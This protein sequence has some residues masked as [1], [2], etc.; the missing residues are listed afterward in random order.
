MN[1][2]KPSYL[3]SYK[4]NPPYQPFYKIL[5]TSLVIL[6][7]IT[8]TSSAYYQKLRFT[9]D[10]EFT[11][12]QLTDLHYGEGPNRDHNSTILTERLLNMTNPDLVV[13]TGDSVSG[14]AWDGLNNTFYYDCWKMWTSPM[15]KLGIPYAY[16]LGNHDDQGDYNRKQICNL[17]ST[18]NF[19]LTQF[20]PSVTG[21]SNYFVPIYSSNQNDKTPVSL[22][23]MLDTNDENCGEMLDSW[24]CFEE[25]EIKWYEEE[26][27]RINKQF[28]YTPKGLAF[29]HI[30][31]P[32]YIESYNWRKSYGSRN[33]NIS[34]PKN[35]TKL[36]QSM[37][38]L[39]NIYG[40]FCGHDHNNDNGAEFYGIDLVYGRKTGY[41]GYGPDF[42]QRGARVIKLKEVYDDVNK[43]MGFSF[44]H[45]V[46]QEDGS[47]EMYR[48]KLWKGSYHFVERCVR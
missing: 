38:Q 20:N 32:E 46:V 10:K 34:C 43:R 16:T 13:I 2:N 45:Y 22:I 6:I 4:T 30:P 24:G 48:K 11:I 3:K 17:D 8:S 41:G 21:A 23:W 37:L 35:N 19:S 36:F 7:L 31:L 12:L 28:G 14:Y 18:N 29:F 9:N 5:L 25:D 27:D 39:N 15:E 44:R 47:L 26:S 33:E 1:I 42:Y 40:T